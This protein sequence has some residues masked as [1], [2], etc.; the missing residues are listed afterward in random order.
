MLQK[1]LFFGKPSLS[2]PK[3]EASVRFAFNSVRKCSFVG[4][5]R[6]KS[7]IFELFIN[8]SKTEKPKT[9]MCLGNGGENQQKINFVF[10][11]KG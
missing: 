9:E 4:K 1:L 11:H 7:E 5:W 8:K 10:V 3:G 6:R 2:L